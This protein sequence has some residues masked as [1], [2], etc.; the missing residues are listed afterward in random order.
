MD[1]EAKATVERLRLEPG[2]ILLV[3]VPDNTTEEEAIRFRGHLQ[4]EM[5]DGVK[6]LIRR[7]GLKHAILGPGADSLVNVRTPEELEM[8]ARQMGALADSPFNSSR[9]K[10]QYLT[11]AKAAYRKL[12]DLRPTPEER[13]HRIMDNL[14]ADLIADGAG[15]EGSTWLRDT[16]AKEINLRDVPVEKV[17]GIDFGMEPAFAP[18]TLQAKGGYRPDPIAA[19]FDANLAE[20]MKQRIDAMFADQPKR[21]SVPL[22]N[23]GVVDFDHEPT[24]AE[25]AAARAKYDTTRAVFD[26]DLADVPVVAEGK[27]NG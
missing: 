9:L 20:L 1:I 18:I 13:L 2:D 5:P 15:M 21:W 17:A 27:G 14:P 10:L 25:I 19:A 24:E 3:T 26:G 22:P 16:V 7:E 12:A 23:G 8:F 4:S 11:W 6:T